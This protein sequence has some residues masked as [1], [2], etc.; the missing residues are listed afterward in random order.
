VRTPT[1][2]L[3]SLGLAICLCACDGKV[4]TIAGTDAGIS[5]SAADAGPV[6]VPVRSIAVSD[7]H[8]MEAIGFSPEDANP[9][10]VSWYPG[11]QQV[12]RFKRS[13][14]GE[15]LPVRAK[16]VI[17]LNG[18]GG[19][20]GPAEVG[21]WLA[22]RGFH[23]LT[24]DYRNTQSVRALA[25]SVPDDGLAGPIE[26]YKEIIEGVDASRNLEVS[27]QDSVFGRIDAALQYLSTYDPEADWGYYLDADGHARLTDVYFFGYS[28]GAGTSTVIGKHF[29]VGRVV[30]AGGPRYIIETNRDWLLSPAATPVD[31]F[32]GIFGIQDPDYADFVETTDLLGWPGDV[33]DTTVV[34]PPFENSHR[35]QT[36]E[37]H[38]AMCM[39]SALDAVCEYAFGIE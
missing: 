6:A 4:L 16:L 13:L 27:P 25:D 18:V 28:F 26:A 14:D 15:P 8:S 11:S 34:P 22:D 23:T 1:L 20:A 35:L 21:S 7:Q 37:G 9:M 30:T 29:E 39:G 2:P 12:A 17:V 32:Y 3:A 38:I 33:V 19:S 10:A 31:R 24:L 36:A 5:P